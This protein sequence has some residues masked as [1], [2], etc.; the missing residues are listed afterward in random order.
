MTA[1]AAF[2]TTATTLLLLSSPEAARC[3]DLEGS[4]TS[5]AQFRVWQPDPPSTISLEFKTRRPDGIILYTD[6]GGYYDFLELK[7]VD[8]AVRLRFN[9]GQVPGVHVLQSS[10]GGNLNDGLAWHKVKVERIDNRVSLQ[11]DEAGKEVMELRP[12]P[13]R[14]EGGGDF[15]NVTRNS[16]VYVGGLPS[17]FATK[18]SSLALPSVVFE[19]RFQGSIRNLIYADP[20][21][22][23]KPRRQELM[24]YKVR[25][26]GGKA[27]VQR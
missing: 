23:G 27:R 1:A 11:V 15:G 25:T 5:Y 17:W 8:G 24:A 13:R 9:F 6:D 14:K 2:L 21:S 10:G 18:L 22:G 16:H 19:P 12:D 3:F 7:L 26:F 20:G 4:Q